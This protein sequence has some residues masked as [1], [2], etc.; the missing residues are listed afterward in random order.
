VVEIGSGLRFRCFQKH[1]AFE[2]LTIMSAYAKAQQLGL[3]GDDAAQV[4]ILNTLTLGDIHAN[5]LGKWLGER[6]L[7]SWDGSGWFGTLQDLIDNGTITGSAV[8]GIQQL[9]AVL[10]G[11]RGDGLAT[12]DPAWAPM[13]YQII[14]GIA[15]VSQDAAALIDSFYALDGGRP[16]KD[17][18][19][20]Q[21]A[22][23]RVA[24][25]AKAE[26]EPIWIAKSAVVDEGIHN[27]TITTIEQILSVIGGE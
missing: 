24:A 3:T 10:V 7:L 6:N 5:K 16:Y 26:I 23:Q 15:Q 9:K 25:L 22:A 20:E 19:V 18:T 2:D 21:F 12:T 11:P 4:A 13:V 14:S 1:W 17:L 8:A 27:G